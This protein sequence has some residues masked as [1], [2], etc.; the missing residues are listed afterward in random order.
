MPRDG[1]K[2]TIKAPFDAIEGK[3]NT[4]KRFND[5]YKGQIPLTASPRK[6]NFSSE[7]L[8]E[9]PVGKNSQ[10]KDKNTSP[11]SMRTPVVQQASSRNKWTF[12]HKPLN[13]DLTEG[14]TFLDPTIELSQSRT[15]NSRVKEI[16]SAEC[17]VLESQDSLV[18]GGPK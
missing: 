1:P 18:K 16:D 7:L 8:M 9:S 5:N 15:R 4:G 2:L 6:I 13:K 14:E 10:T 3:S 11:A 12:M 17:Q